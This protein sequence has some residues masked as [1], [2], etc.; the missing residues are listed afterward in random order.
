MSLS[1]ASI[2]T[3]LESV[4]MTEISK[5]I[6]EIFSAFTAEVGTLDIIASHLRYSGFDINLIKE[7]IYRITD[8]MD[9]KLVAQDMASIC[10]L[11]VMRGNN[12]DKVIAKS[13]NPA[14]QKALGRLK[15][16]YKLQG[17][18]GI[19][20]PRTLTPIRVSLAMWPITL[21]CAVKNPSPNVTDD[22]MWNAMEVMG[23]KPMKL[24]SDLVIIPPFI[25]TNAF[26]PCSPHTLTNLHL[27]WLILNNINITGQQINASSQETILGSLLASY[28]QIEKFYKQAISKQVAKEDLVKAIANFSN[29]SF[30]DRQKSWST[31]EA[32]IAKAMSQMVGDQRIVE[33]SLKIKSE[34]TTNKVSKGPA[35]SPGKYRDIRSNF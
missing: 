12:I 28:S 1:L 5:V 13:T 10:M 11:A 22:M 8:K 33:I 15:D 31:V 6:N 35:S 20:T 3:D 14:V 18:G 24:G 30:D 25:K 26:T 17:P 27:L 9:R 4:N 7:Q 2:N 32:E 23:I 16:V 29:V 21:A 34:W 19:L